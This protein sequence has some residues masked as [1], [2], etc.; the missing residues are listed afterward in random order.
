[1]VLPLISLKIGDDYEKAKKQNQFPL[2]LFSL[3]LLPYLC[4]AIC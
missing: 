1:M 4:F 2:I 3:T